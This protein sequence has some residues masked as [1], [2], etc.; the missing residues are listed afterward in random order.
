MNNVLVSVLMPVYNAEPYIKQA[1]DSIL[2]QTFTNFEFI[3]INDGSSDASKDIILSYKDPR[4]AYLENE[5]N[6]KLIET[7]NKGFILCKGKY[8]V[9]MDAD[10]ISF[11]ERIAKQV[12]FMEAH[13]EV[14]IAGTAA[15]NFG[16]KEGK[17]Y[18]ETDDQLI[19]Y[20]FLHECHL[21]HPSA[22]IRTKV[23]RDHNLTM[24]ILHGEDYDFF[25]RIAEHSKLANLK[26]VLLHYRQ[27]EN[28]MSKG[29][30]EITERH[31]NEIKL[32]LFQKLDPLFVM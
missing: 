11:P 3:I 14:G 21:L 10:D 22:I 12:A 32:R 23:L 5:K 31:S 26:E 17:F 24:T 27:L 16:F 1:I 13:P 9:R 4:I 29:N 7:L 25:L 19:R 2:N 18:Y 30:R 8:I 28:S 6:L 15:E 20:K